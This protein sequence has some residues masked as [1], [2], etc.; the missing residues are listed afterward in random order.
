MLY[1]Q[2]GDCIVAIDSV[3]SH[4]PAY[5]D[6]RSQWVPKA[7]SD[8]FVYGSSMPTAAFDWLPLLIVT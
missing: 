4:Y 2:N 7:I 1:P 6:R 8:T 5:I 3:T